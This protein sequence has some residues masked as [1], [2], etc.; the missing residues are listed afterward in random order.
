VI[1]TDVPTDPLVGLKL[2]IVGT[3]GPVVTVKFVDEVPVPPG[4]VTVMGPV[5]VAPV[6]TLAVT[7]VSLFTVNV[8]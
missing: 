4:V 5:P 2:V 1:T 7:C 8:L 6:G 3:G